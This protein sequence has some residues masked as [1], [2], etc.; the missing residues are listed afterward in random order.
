MKTLSVTEARKNLGHW[1]QKAIAGEDI[2]IVLNGRIVGL[3]EVKVYSEGY[4]LAEFGLKKEQLE[5]RVHV[6]ARKTSA[7]KKPIRPKA[8][9]GR[10]KQRNRR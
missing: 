7:N 10:L 2:G 8:H 1:V 4:A 5:R 3:R 9:R 6:V